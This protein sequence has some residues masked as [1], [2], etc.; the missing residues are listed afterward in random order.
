[1]SIF[2]LFLAQSVASGLAYA[3]NPLTTIDVNIPCVENYTATFNCLL[4]GNYSE[5]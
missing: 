2:D 3:V 5:F 1:M 4:N